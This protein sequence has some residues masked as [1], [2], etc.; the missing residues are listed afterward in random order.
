MKKEENH[1]NLNK[2][3]W[4]KWSGW[5][6]DKSWMANYLRNTQLKLISILNIRENINFLDIGC[7]TGFAIGEVAEL[8]NNNSQFYGIDISSKMIEKAKNNFSGK[9]NCHFFEA[10]V[11]SIPLKADFFD[12]IICV[13]SF[14]HYLNPEKALEEMFRVLK[15]G[16]RLYILEQTTE[17][18]IG[19]FV[20]RMMKIGEPTH[21]KLYNSKEFKIMFER[22]GLKYIAMQKI[23]PFSNVHIG[24]K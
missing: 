21:V 24:E 7:G 23:K 15:K 18:M 1:R 4:D 22:T 17:N 3:K 12:I 16:G 9:N 14:H 10:T 13:N 6:D 20:D 19:R 2:A 5:Y 8:T 11:E